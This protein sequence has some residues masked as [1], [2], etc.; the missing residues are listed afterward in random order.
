MVMGFNGYPL[1]GLVVALTLAGCSQKPQPAPARV[2]PVATAVAPAAPRTDGKVQTQGVERIQFQEEYLGPQPGSIASVQALFARGYVD[3]A[4]RETMLAAVHTD[5]P[6]LGMRDVHLIDPVRKF[7][8]SEHATTTA[9]D[10]IRS[11]LEARLGPLGD[12]RYRQIWQSLP[13]NGEVRHWSARL[14]QVMAG[15]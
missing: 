5:Y 6:L 14:K 15:R 7:L 11:G 10:Y 2:A 3:S 13:Q 4:L 12:A 9:H 8:T 1:M